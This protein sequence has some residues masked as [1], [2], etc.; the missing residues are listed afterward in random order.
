MIIAFSAVS[1]VAA[2]RTNIFVDL[3]CRSTLWSVRSIA[4]SS[5]VP[6]DSNIPGKSTSHVPLRPANSSGYSGLS[7]GILGTIVC[8]LCL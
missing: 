6:L 8:E 7:Y 1:D 4:M 2:T 5:S 3:A